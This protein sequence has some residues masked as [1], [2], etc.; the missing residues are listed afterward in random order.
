MVRRPPRSTRTDTLFP[1]TTLCR[2]QRCT[3]ANK[4]AAFTPL[5][6][7]QHDVEYEADHLAGRWLIR[8][9]RQAHNFRLMQATAKTI[10]KPE[11]WQD[12]VAHND[13]ELTEDFLP[14]KS[15]ERRVGNGFVS[16]WR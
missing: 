3:S 2:S 8:T 14:F 6:P 16:R 7:R 11:Q 15:D 4:P 10:D 13:Q 5:V 9:N 1:Y 12:G